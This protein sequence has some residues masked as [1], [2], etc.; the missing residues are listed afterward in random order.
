VQAA[1]N[2]ISALA[3][4]LEQEKAKHAAVKA[5]LAASKRAAGKQQKANAEL[6]AAKQR[7]E[8]ALEKMR[9]ELTALIKCGEGGVG[10]R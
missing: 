6:A 3:E 2:T 4:L 8:A 7:A 1:K 9:A 10:E 5:E